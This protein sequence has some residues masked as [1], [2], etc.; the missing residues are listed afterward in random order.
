MEKVELSE[1]TKKIDP[2]VQM[3]KEWYLVTARKN[4]GKVNTMV[5]AWGGIGNLFEKKVVF[6]TIR[7]QRYTKE[8]VDESGRFTITFFNGHM[9]A[10]TL[11]GTKSGRE[12]PDKIQNSGLNLTEVDGQPTF[13]EG[14][15][16]LNCKV[17][18]KQ[19]Y[20]PEC[21]VEKELANA[22]Y[23]DK[24]YSWPYVAEIESAYEM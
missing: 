22:C 21:F 11:L 19:Q 23:P 15:L 18:Y 4:D 8:F 3:R 5:G 24:D 6:V 20:K 10:L 9:D 13:K 7:P 2:V 16:V 1:I 17:I 14:R 12:M